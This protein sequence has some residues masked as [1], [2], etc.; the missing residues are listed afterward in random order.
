[1][2]DSS[3][4]NLAIARRYLA[5][6]ERG[7]SEAEVSEFFTSDVVQEEFPNRITP[8]GAKRDLPALR[9]AAARGRAAM[10]RQTYDVVTAVASGSTL[11]LEVRW[12]GVLA[13]PF[14]TLASGDEMRARLA[15]FLEFRDGKIA[16]QR[17][18]D[19]FEPW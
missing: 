7:L 8:A 2:T 6:V 4:A 18:Y 1:V 13:V 12:T 15:I 16:R 19:C 5:A 10:T 11:A 14:G 3:S 17:N 9:E